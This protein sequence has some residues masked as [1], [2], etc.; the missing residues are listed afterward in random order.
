[1]NHWE[2]AMAGDAAALEAALEAD[3][4]SI[5]SPGPGGWPALHLAAHFGHTE[6]VELLLARGADV[7]VRSI[8]DMRNL[9]LHAAAAGRIPDRRAAI[10]Q[11]LLDAGTPADATQAGGFTALHAAVQNSDQASIDLL[12][13]RGA[14][15]NRAA[16][17]G[18]TP[19]SMR[20]S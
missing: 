2:A 12:L 1:M 14:D 6:C 10:L 3:S 5:N 4:S 9:A 17:D 7:Q 11:R 20:S 19:A 18:R 8:N 15:M 13:S 16:A